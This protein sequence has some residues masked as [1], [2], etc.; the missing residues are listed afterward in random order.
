MRFCGFEFCFLIFGE[1]FENYCFHLCDFGGFIC[2]NLVRVRLVL[3]VVQFI[4]SDL[5]W[6]L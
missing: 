6:Y 5:I 4:E 1:V 3:V 2:I